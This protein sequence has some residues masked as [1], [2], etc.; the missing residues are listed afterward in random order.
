MIC[1]AL[2]HSPT[3]VSRSLKRG[4]IWR[5]IDQRQ[6]PSFWSGVRGE[7]LEAECVFYK[8]VHFRDANSMYLPISAV[9]TIGPSA[10]RQ[11][12]KRNEPG[13]KWI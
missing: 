2:A 3:G 4:A 10:Y 5:S 11:A 13:M 9:S 12:K 8:T 1:S 6:V 7:A